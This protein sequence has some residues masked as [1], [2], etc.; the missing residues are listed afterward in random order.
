MPRFRVPRSTRTMYGTI[1]PAALG[2]IAM[3]EGGAAGSNGLKQPLVG[4]AVG[5]LGSG[6]ASAQ[7]AAVVW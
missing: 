2:I 7:P 4:G 5:G 6:R 3:S 1:A